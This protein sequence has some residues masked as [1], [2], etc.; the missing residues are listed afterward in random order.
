MPKKPVTPE[1]IF[2]FI[3]VGDPQ[4]RPNSD[5]VLFAKK[6]LSQEKNKYLTH[7]CLAQEGK[8]AIQLTQGDDSCSSGRWSPD[9][10]QI[11]FISG[12]SEHISQI[13]LLNMAG[14]EAR[15][16]T[17]LEEGSIGGIKWSPTGKH[18]AFSFRPTDPKWTQKAEK[19][20]KEKNLSTPAREID[21]IWYREDGDGYFLGAR[22]AL[23]VL[24]VTTGESK[25]IYEPNPRLDSMS[26]AWNPQG[27]EL[28]VT[29]HSKENPIFDRWNDDIYRVDLNG[30]ATQVS[31]N[32]RGP[33]GS[34]TWSPDGQHIAFTGRPDEKSAWGAQNTRAYMIP[35]AGGDVV[36]LSDNHDY[37]LGAATL[38]DTKEAAFDAPLAWLDNQDLLIQVVQHG[39]CHVGK[40]ST[41]G[42]LHQVT[43]GR[44][45]FG[46]GLPSADGKKL[47]VVF[48]GPTELQEVG[49]LDLT[50]GN[51]AKL[52]DFNSGWLSEYKISEP[53]EFW[54]EAEDGHKVH[55]W[56]LKPSGFAAGKK[57]PAVLEIHGGP[58]TQYGCTFMHEFQVLAANGYVVFYSNP[59][60]SRGYGEAHCAAI[61]GDWGNKDWL[62]IQA[63]TQHMVSQP[64][65][66]PSK[67]GIM[68]GSY[69]GYMT[70][71]AVGHSKAYKA[72]ITDRCVSNLVSMA[73]SSD[74]PWAES[75]YWPG[76]PYG[77]LDNIKG[78]W[79]QSPIAYF[80]GVT[81]PMLIIHSEGD[82]RCNVEQGEQV[83]AALQAQGVPSRFVR[84]PQSTF[85]GLS[86]SGPPDLRI[87]RLN[88][89]L[90]WWCK[91]LV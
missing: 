88:E 89:I 67:V 50:T 83:F 45:L 5:Q 90:T 80:E 10:S 9:G 28:A 62:D 64:Y 40:L 91:W 58:H 84:Y 22:N 33:K 37:C 85:H 73:G 26:F 61:A 12:R 41:S 13:F 4:V 44:K 78:L 60:G 76:L 56:V 30:K 29:R 77:K 42:G 25:K 24:D 74:Y 21:D 68:G 20:R 11:A 6:T 52:T 34:L 3:L 86:R 87:H 2:E 48:G 82:L 39:T 32:A 81:T 7:L 16:I 15:Q 1:T 79:A 38:S 14:G 72:A 43:E 8:D 23:W 66:D 69:G 63:V 70:N 51:L 57:Y 35:A 47:G 36:A 75:T 31:T 71:W 46:F 54:A 17:K 18:I 65:V 49:L 27:T 59:R 19:E 53:E 55:G